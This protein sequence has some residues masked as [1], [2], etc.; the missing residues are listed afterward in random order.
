MS[1]RGCPLL[2]A[3]SEPFFVLQRRSFIDGCPKRCVG[4]E[5]LRLKRDALVVCLG[6]GTIQMTVIS[7]SYFQASVHISQ[8]I[9]HLGN[10]SQ[11][12]ETGT[13]TR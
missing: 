5:E 4:C 8:M 10:L 11:P 12:T 9:P 6:D 1:V 3:E 7:P 13:L 2:A